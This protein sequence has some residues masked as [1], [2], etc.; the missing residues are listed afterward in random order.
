MK[1]P[2]LLRISDNLLIAIFMYNIL[3][4]IF[5]YNLLIAFF[6]YNLLIAIF[7][8]N[9]LNAIFKYNLLIAIFKYN[10]LIAIF[11]YNLLIAIFK[12]NLSLLSSGI[13]I[14]A[15]CCS[16]VFDAVNKNALEIWKFQMYFMVMEYEKKTA[17]VP[18]LSLLQHIFLAVRWL[19]R[20]CLRRKHIV[21]GRWKGE[22][23]AIGCGFNPKARRNYM[24][25]DLSTQS[26]KQIDMIL[27]Q[28]L[29][30][31]TIFC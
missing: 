23:H 6:M 13:I 30:H 10:V 25:V 21:K 8:Y 18:P 19:L 28:N 3:I 22:C 24:C 4:A 2:I 31:Y 9:L 12:Y 5:R 16:H 15:P 7:R 20:R 14:P 11:K 17:I 1:T 26:I 29:T 27:C